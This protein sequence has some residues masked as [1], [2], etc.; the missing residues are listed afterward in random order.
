MQNNFCPSST[1]D[2]VSSTKQFVGFSRKFGMGLFAKIHIWLIIFARCLSKIAK[3][4]CYLH[5]VCPSVRP[6]VCPHAS[7][8]FPLNGF[9]WNLM[10]VDLWKI[11]RDNSCAVKIWQEHHILYMKTYVDIYIDIY[12]Y[13]F[14]LFLLGMRKCFKVF[15]KI[16]THIL[17]KIFPL[18]TKNPSFMW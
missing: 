12:I 2:L 11:C 18:P 1:R 9:S 7:T 16:K 8:R 6:T 10:L 17:H 5:Y 15:E 3:S 13:M 4:N 14:L